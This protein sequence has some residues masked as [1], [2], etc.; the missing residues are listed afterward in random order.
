M[1]IKAIVAASVLAAV[2]LGAPA[3]ADDAPAY[4]ITKSVALGAPDRWDCVV[5]DPASHRVYIAHGDRVSVVD[6]R[7]GTVIGQVEGFPGGTHGIGISTLTGRGYTNDGKA[8]TAHSFDLKTLKV[9]KTIKAE[10]DADGIV[11][12]PVSGHVFVINGDPGTVTVIDPK[13]DTAIA[14]IAAGAKLEFGV[15]GDTGK[16]YVNGE[17]KKE[18]V[19]IDTGTNKIDARW[20]IAACTSPH[21]IAIDTAAH[22]LFSTCVNGV[23]VVVDTESGAVITTVPI[24]KGTDGAGF[25]PKR[26]LVFS[27]NGADGTLSVIQERDAGSFVPVATVPTAMTGRTMD[28]DPETGRIYV[29][30]AEIDAK[31]TAPNG[32]PKPVPG[33]LK[34]LL[35]DPVK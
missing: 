2:T 32:R 12:D 33:S 25:D 6:G 17:A 31:A 28:I 13:T 23:M 9:L 18:I 3:R 34:L 22:R 7:D 15:A 35:I 24:G 30:A 8:G 29:A 21:G 16:I 11:V 5:F 19:R 20:P 14:T 1:S 26:K 10:D 4:R 27:S